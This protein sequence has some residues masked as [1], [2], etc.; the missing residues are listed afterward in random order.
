[1]RSAVKVNVA[2]TREHLISSPHFPFSSTLRF[3]KRRNRSSLCPLAFKKIYPGFKHS[4]T[5]SVLTPEIKTLTFA[6]DFKISDILF[7]HRS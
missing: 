1:M 4:L 7:I 3:H 5:L 2:A 6:P